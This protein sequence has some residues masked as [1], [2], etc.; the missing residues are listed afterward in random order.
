[1]SFIIIIIRTKQQS[2]SQSRH[3][4]AIFVGSCLSLSLVTASGLCSGVCLVIASTGSTAAMVGS[5][6]S[7]M[8]GQSSSTPAAVQQTSNAMVLCHPSLI[9]SGLSSL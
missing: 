4:S 8:S 1:L 7:A 3:V 2:V 5:Q 9:I 6:S